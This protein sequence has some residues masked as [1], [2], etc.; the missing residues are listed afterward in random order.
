MRS[1]TLH[2]TVDD[3]TDKILGP[4]LVQKECLQGYFEVV[5][6]MLGNHGIPASIYS[7]RHSIFHSPKTAHVSFEEQLA[8]KEA[9][10]TQFERAMDEL[11]IALIPARSP[12]AKGCIE[13]LW[14]TLQS[15]LPVELKI[16]GIADL[17][18]AN[19]FFC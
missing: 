1:S 7:D 14:D 11:G 15:R 10:K 4:Y 6:Q 5:R 8:G 19:Q 17:H 3:A 12:Q 9:P 16:A 2:G 18:G 13:R